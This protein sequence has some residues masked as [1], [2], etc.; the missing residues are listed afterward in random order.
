MKDLMIKLAGSVFIAMQSFINVKAQDFKAEQFVQSASIVLQGNIEKVFPLF[1]AIE[2][3]KWSEDWH[4]TP[5]FPASGN[6]E[7]GFIF[8]SPDHVPNS[9]P[10]TWVVSKYDS[11]SHQVRYIITSA[12]RVTIITVNCS[13]IDGNSTKAEITY[14]LTGLSEEGNEISHHLIT[15]M[16]KHNLK[17]W[18]TAINNYLASARRY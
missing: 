1:G 18:E 10:L 4:P 3:K 13:K 9:P 16:F 11:S 5:V 15:E 17:D 12:N 6:M 7:E 14:C 2:E 8:H